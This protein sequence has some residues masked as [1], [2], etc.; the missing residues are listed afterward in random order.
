L[1]AAE[2]RYLAA[3]NFQQHTTPSTASFLNTMAHYSGLASKQDTINAYTADRYAKG[4]T[5]AADVPRMQAAAQ[6]ATGDYRQAL[7]YFSAHQDELVDTFTSKTATGAQRSSARSVYDQLQSNVSRL[8][9][10]ASAETLLAQTMRGQYRG[11][12]AVVNTPGRATR[13]WS[14]LAVAHGAAAGGGVTHTT[15]TNIQIDRKTIASSVQTELL[16]A[17]TRSGKNV[18]APQTGLRDH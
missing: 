4:L 5:T 15:V 17:S 3:L 7:K 1:N 8:R 2:K 10:D 16:Q 11:A 13:D 6:T 9:D 18:L 14:Y 12:E